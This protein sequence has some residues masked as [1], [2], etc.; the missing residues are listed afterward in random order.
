VALGVPATAAGYGPVPF[1]RVVRQPGE[2]G[3]IGTTT[4]LV[5]GAG[6]WIDQPEDL[7][8]ALGGGTALTR[9]PE[10]SQRET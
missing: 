6:S 10:A 7:N 9:M 3:E 5:R 2:A 8:Y 4:C 1:L